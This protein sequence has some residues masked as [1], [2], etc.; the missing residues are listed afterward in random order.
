MNDSDGRDAGSAIRFPLSGGMRAWLLGVAGAGAFLEL[1]AATPIPLSGVLAFVLR[2]LLWIA[3]YRLASEILLASAEGETG[4]PSLS[5]IESADGLAIRHIALWLLATLALVVCSIY[6]GPIG[7]LAG[8]FALAAMLPA[9]TIILTLSKSLSEALIPTQWLRLAARIGQAD[10]LRLCAAL[11]AAALAYLAIAGIM[12]GLGLGQGLRNVVQLAYWAFAVFAWFHLAGRTVY[13]HRA[14][15]NLVEPDTE[16]AQTPEKFTRDPEALW[17][18]IRSQGGTRDM[19]AELAR[20][21]ERA[22][23]RERR[24][25]HGRLHLETLLLAF[26]APEEALDRTSRML[27]VDRDFALAS[28]DSMLAL[29]RAAADHHASWLVGQLCA[30]YLA[31]F[32]GSVKRDEVRLTACEALREE[33]SANRTKAEAWFRE[34]MTAEL[35]DAQRA[36]LASLAPCYLH[37]PPGPD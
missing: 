2:L 10:Y 29:I 36:R 7:V 25:E 33:S 16:P 34:L 28:P 18:E 35:A 23:T 13:R 24:L 3:I 27:E 1:L 20:Q 19:H 21:L 32:P 6:T 9:A 26:E 4:A 8:S 37:A 17:E 12:A 30:N 22:G 15:L 31:A 14:E 11:L 5:G